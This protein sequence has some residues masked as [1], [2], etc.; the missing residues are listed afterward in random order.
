M[1]SLHW[2]LGLTLKVYSFDVGHSTDDHFGE[3]V[4]F[5]VDKLRAHTGLGCVEEGLSSKS[6]SLQTE[7]ALDELYTFFKGKSVTR[8]DTG[9]M[10]VVLN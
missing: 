2:V 4:A 6:V 8:D 5:S 3:E 1:D 9:G 7:S 10:D